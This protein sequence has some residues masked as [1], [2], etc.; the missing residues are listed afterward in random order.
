MKNKTIQQTLN[1]VFNLL[2]YTFVLIP[3]IAGA[4][5]FTNLLTNWEQYIHPNLAA[6]LP[7][8][9]GIFMK[10]VGIIEIIA[11]CIVFKKP[12]S[13]WTNCGSLVNSIALSFIA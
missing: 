12:G 8:S 1:P 3:I 4:D 11:G 5:K 13:W 6:M 10:I 7:F 2:K 9:P